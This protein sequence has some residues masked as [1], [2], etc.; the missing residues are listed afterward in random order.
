MSIYTLDFGSS[1]LR[2]QPR[3]FPLAWQHSSHRCYEFKELLTSEKCPWFG[4]AAEIPPTSLLQCLTYMGHNGQESPVPFPW[5]R[6]I[7]WP[8]CSASSK[9]PAHHSGSGQAQTLWEMHPHSALSLCLSYVILQRIFSSKSVFS[10]LP[11]LGPC[12]RLGL[13]RTRFRTI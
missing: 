6:S 1:C 11:I 2:S 12:L 9:A 3:F 5:G 13:W 7:P 8:N 4:Y 10:K